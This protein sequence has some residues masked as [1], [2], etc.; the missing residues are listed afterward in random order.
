M[1]GIAP[2]RE[3]RHLKYAYT[4]HWQFGD[5]LSTDSEM[6]SVSSSTAEY[7][8]LPTCLSVCLWV[9]L[10]V[11]QKGILP[12]A[13]DLYMFRH[14]LGLKHNFLQRRP[15][16]KII[17]ISRHKENMWSCLWT[18]L[19]AQVVSVSVQCSKGFEHEQKTVCVSVCYKPSIVSSFLKTWLLSLITILYV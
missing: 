10:F 6:R 15:Q 7:I 8:C 11:Y 18:T 16:V 14:C 19:V 3:V 9:W 4:V 1:F 5:S 2:L 12:L 13:S 17:Q